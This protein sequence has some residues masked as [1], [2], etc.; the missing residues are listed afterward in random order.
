MKRSVRKWRVAL[1]ALITLAVVLVW[2]PVGSEA[3]SSTVHA[4]T[5]ASDNHHHAHVEENSPQGALHGTL[6][7]DC[8]ASAIGCCMMTHCHPGISVDAL[9]MATVVAS[10]RTTAAAPVRGL[11][12]D[13]GVIL[14]PPRRLWL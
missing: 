3:S 6:D 14:P 12:S 13:P 5:A 10:D 1:V 2:P 8:Q 11:G 7:E 9:E 4:A